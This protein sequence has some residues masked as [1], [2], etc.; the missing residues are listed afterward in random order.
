MPQC[1]NGERPPQD[2]RG[3]QDLPKNQHPIGDWTNG[4]VHRHLP[5]SPWIVDR[6]LSKSGTIQNPE[7][8]PTENYARTT[9]EIEPS[10]ARRGRTLGRSP[11]MRGNSRM[12]TNNDIV[13]RASA[14]ESNAEF[15]RRW[16]LRQPSL[17]TQRIKDRTH[18]ASHPP[19]A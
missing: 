3:G 15:L 4:C 13:N 18:L 9:I 10:V 6:T 8:I 2:D 17:F 16:T 19:W 12:Y 5:V 14:S 11:L 1:E 7:K